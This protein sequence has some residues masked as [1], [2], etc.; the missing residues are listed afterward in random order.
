MQNGESNMGMTSNASADASNNK[1]ADT[2][3]EREQQLGLENLG[4]EIERLR[5]QFPNTQDLYREVCVLMF[6]RHGTTPTANKLY[7]LVRKGSMSAPAEA[8]ASFWEHLREKSRVRIEHPDLPQALK[9]AAGELTAALWSSAQH[10]AQDTLAAFRRDAQ[11]AVETATLERASAQAERDAGQVRLQDQQTI[12]AEALRRIVA[13]EQEAA[14][15][16]STNR[17]LAAQLQHAQDDAAAN[18]H[19]HQQQ[20]LEARREFAAELDK[21]RA[22]N[23]LADERSLANDTRAL[24]EIDRERTMGV[25]LQ[26]ELDAVRAAAIQAASQAA[27]RHRSDVAALQQQLGDLRQQAGVAQGHLQAAISGRD[28]IALE[29][30]AAQAQSAVAAA[31]AAANTAAAAAALHAELNSLQR[32]NEESR[33]M[34]AEV[35]LQLKGRRSRV[36]RKPGG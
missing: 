33:R 36:Y 23:R 34:L 22:A 31:V 4:L 10:L 20:L 21:L 15:M 6:F 17:A 24:L 30:K 29:L 18:R 28:A 3:V 11:L 26:K 8:L 19:A 32:Q 5:E 14:G 27:E 25:K 35:Q 2:P 1:V 16:A 12:A 7:Q 13:L 9:T